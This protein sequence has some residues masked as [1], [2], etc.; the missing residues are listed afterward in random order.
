MDVKEVTWY[1]CGNCGLVYSAREWAEQCCKP[2]K[3]EKCG[4]EIP[5]KTMWSLCDACR[6]EKEI[7]DEQQRFYKAQKYTLANCPKEKCQ[8]MYSDVYTYNEGFFSDIEELKGF[9][10]WK[11][12][13]LPDY[14]Y[15][16]REQ[17]FSI[18]VDAMLE[19]SCE[20]LHEDA[21]ENLD[22]VEELRSY[23]EDWCKKQSG[24]TTF[25]RDQNA[26]ILLESEK[27]GEAME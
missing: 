1:K 15:C 3:C 21:Y 16:T 20:E 2:E 10:S 24:A 17:K 12:I 27:D 9:C 7:E 14:V 6:K 18:D 8:M 25:Y 11:G 19:N 4:K 5:Y 23:I 22:G 26:V 13:K